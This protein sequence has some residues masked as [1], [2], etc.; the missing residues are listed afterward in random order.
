MPWLIGTSRT[1]LIPF[2]DFQ[3]GSAQIA[4]M[5]ISR[6]LV[7]FFLFSAIHNQAKNCTFFFNE[8]LLLGPVNVDIRNWAFSNSKIFHIFN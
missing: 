8:L 4:V 5:D 6:K 1:T 7:S 3:L 2:N